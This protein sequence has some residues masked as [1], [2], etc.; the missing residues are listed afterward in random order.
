MR[1]KINNTC[2]SERVLPQED[3]EESLLNTINSPLGRVEG[4]GKMKLANTS[5]TKL[6]D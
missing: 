4:V 3:D 6:E 5:Q 2:H 1:R